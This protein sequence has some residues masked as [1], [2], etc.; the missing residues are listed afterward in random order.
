M[1]S[2]QNQKVLPRANIDFRIYWGDKRFCGNDF[3]PSQR[4]TP[5][6]T[7]SLPGNPRKGKVTVRELSKLIGKL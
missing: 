6:S 2:A 1:V 5:Q 7:E 3:E 4:E